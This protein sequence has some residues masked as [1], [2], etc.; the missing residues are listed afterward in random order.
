M[1]KEADLSPEWSSLTLATGGSADR[2]KLPTMESEGGGR[3]RQRGSRL[4]A[5]RSSTLVV[6]N[7][8]VAI[9]SEP[10]RDADASARL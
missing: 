9:Q 1:K 4:D 7:E 10:A 6:P 8:D 3:R 5:E 2:R